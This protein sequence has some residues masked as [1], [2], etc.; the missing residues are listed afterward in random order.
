MSSQGLLHTLYRKLELLEQW[1][2]EVPNAHVR[3]F[4]RRY[5]P[6]NSSNISDFEI[7]M[8]YASHAGLNLASHARWRCSS[9]S[10]F[11][12]ASNAVGVFPLGFRELL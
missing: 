5:P 1:T 8:L 9:A 7:L 4:S 2:R 12:D 11:V 10:L 6:S 3:S